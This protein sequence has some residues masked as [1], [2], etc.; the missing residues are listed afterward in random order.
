MPV[1]HRFRPSVT[2]GNLTFD[3]LYDIEHNESENINDGVK[4][5]FDNSFIKTADI[6]GVKRFEKIYRINGNRNDGI[7]VRK[8]IVYNSMIYRPPFTRQRL[9]LLLKNVFGE[10]NFTYTIDIENFSVTISI[11]PTNVSMYENYIRKVRDIVP[12]NLNLMFST[13]YTYIFLGFLKY[14]SDAIY[15]DVG[16]GNGDYIYTNKGYVFVGEGNG[17]YILEPE[18]EF[19][20]TELCYYTY[21]ELSKYSTALLSNTIYPP[22]RDTGEIV[23]LE[24]TGSAFI[25]E[26]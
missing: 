12:A 4:N 25:S 5:V 13:P 20:D 3:T 9:Y 17:D 10:G 26:I 6:D 23:D 21:K 11:P 24:G 19:L 14:G 15:T 8:E 2:R 1:V 16:E 7:E 18:T 22:D